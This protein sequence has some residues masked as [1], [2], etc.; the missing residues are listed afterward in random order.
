MIPCGCGRSHS[1]TA[2]RLRWPILEAV[3]RLARQFPGRLGKGILYVGDLPDDILAAKRA[4]EKI[5]IK[6]A[7]FPKYSR[8]PLTTLEELKK[9]G[10]DFYLKAPQDLLKITRCSEAPGRH[11]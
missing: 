5:R 7:A 11:R 1:G 9:I 3:R 4:A 10:P 2:R 6:S 8:D